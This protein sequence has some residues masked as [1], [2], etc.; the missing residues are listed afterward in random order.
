MW[1]RHF[2]GVCWYGHFDLLV[3]SLPLPDNAADDVGYRPGSKEI[4]VDA[5]R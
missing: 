4:L 2:P 1:H 3:S 5:F